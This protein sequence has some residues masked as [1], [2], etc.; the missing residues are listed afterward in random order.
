MRQY[1]IAP[2][3]IAL[4]V[5]SVAIAS[6]AAFGLG[7]GSAEEAATPTA[8]PTDA[9]TVEPSA[10]ATPTAQPSAT[11]GVVSDGA[12]GRLTI[13]R[14]G[15]FVTLQLPG[16]EEVAR[17]P[18]RNLSAA[19]SAD[20]QWTAAVHE[21]GAQGCS[22]K[23]TGPDATETVLRFE[24]G[25]S[26]PVWSPEGATLALVIDH[27]A[28]DFITSRDLVVLDPRAPDVQTVVFSSGPFLMPFV[29]ED[30][31]HLV[32]AAAP[33]EG[34]A[35]RV[36]RVALDGTQEDVGLAESQI[37]YFYPSA[38]GRTAA[39]TQNGANGWR[40]FALDLASGAITDYGSMGSDPAGTQP[41]VPSATV[42]GP[43]YVAWSPDGR[44]LGF[45]GGYDAP[46]F[47]TIVDLDSGAAVRTQFE[48]GYPGEIKWSPDGSRV[49]V[50][51]YD[52][53]RTRHEVYIVDPATGASRHVSSGCVIVWSPDGRFLAQ[54]IDHTPG[55][56]IV[57]VETGEYGMITDVFGETPLWWE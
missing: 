38:D 37:A 12:S 45:G 51:T 33:G 26:T 54:H 31:G 48:E 42:K 14:G 18:S 25:V 52:V 5:G 3:I 10:V 1:L 7:D 47:M 20:G 8:A 30:A 49:A 46:Y 15:D 19:V 53:E 57:D 55:V 56:A 17:E 6:P 28:G 29:W 13:L 2:V 11:P 50:S 40:L 27:V 4:L 34:A 32:V 24:S 43:M 9:P 23:I 39:F 36:V 16:G 21:C 22:L 35:S 44:Q 41:P